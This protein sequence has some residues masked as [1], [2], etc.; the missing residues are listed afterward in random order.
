M[1]PGVA[2]ISPQRLHRLQQQGEALALV[3]VRTP[4]EYRAGHALGAKLIPLDELTPEGLTKQFSQPEL[5]HSEPLYL[6]CQSGLRA[7]Q[8]A[9]RLHASGYHNLFLLDGGTQAWENAGLPMQRCVKAMSLERQVQITIGLLLI[10][11]VF[12]GFTVHELF[13]AAAA[14][15]GAGLIVAGITRWCGL[16]RLLA[17]LPWNRRVGCPEQ[18][19]H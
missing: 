15:L 10:L 16:A 8:A 5:G 6:T 14:L 4:A 3:D 1:N 18:A 19:S 2:S 12:F 9:E 11:K 17:R 13:F 7:Q